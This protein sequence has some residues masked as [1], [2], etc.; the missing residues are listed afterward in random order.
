MS[1]DFLSDLPAELLEEILAIESL[2]LA[3]LVNA[4][5]AHPRLRD[6]V[7]RPIRNKLHFKTDEIALGLFNV[8]VD[9][10]DLE[11]LLIAAAGILINSLYVRFVK[12]DVK[13]LSRLYL[14]DHLAQCVPVIPSVT[15][16]F[17]PPP[18]QE[19]KLEPDMIPAFRWKLH[20][21]LIALAGF[22]DTLEAVTLICT[23]SIKYFRPRAAARFW[24][25]E[26]PFPKI[27]AG[28]LKSKLFWK[29][30]ESPVSM[31]ELKSVPK[32][33]GVGRLIVLDPDLRS[34]LRIDSHLSLDEWNSIMPHLTLPL[35]RWLTVSIDLMNLSIL[36]L[37]L[38]RHEKIFDPCPPNLYPVL[39]PF[40]TS[41][42]LASHSCQ[43]ILT[44]P[45]GFLE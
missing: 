18:K 14:L 22:K 24:H 35:L 20:T 12:A 31:I 4:S 5:K 30:V 8:K 40:P 23:D 19:E 32:S 2:A 33:K 29:L 34:N 3:D 44:E 28:A 36:S 21:T 16:H 43:L 42:Y 25:R 1:R 6:I 15:L 39:P 10:A 41:S 13:D 7:V 45:L 9:C 17:P 38:R 11:A 26:A 37:F 27:D